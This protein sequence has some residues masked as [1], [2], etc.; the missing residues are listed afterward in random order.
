MPKNCRALQ[1]AGLLLCGVGFAIC[2]SGGVTGEPGSHFTVDSWSTREGLPQSSVISVIQTRDGYLWLGTLNGL[3]RFDGSH[4]KVF[5]EENTPGLKS[6]RIV[7]LFEDTRTNLWVGTDA[8]GVALVKDGRVTNF[9]IGRSGHDGG[10]LYA[11]EDLNGL[12][13][14]CTA[15]GRSGYYQNGKMQVVPGTISKELLLRASKTLL[16]SRSGGFWVMQNGRVQKWRDDRPEKDFGPFPW[17][18]VPVSSA[19]EDKDGNLIVGTLGAGIFWYDADGKCRQISKEQGLS[20]TFVLS[21]CMDRDGNLW[22]GTD[23]DGLD[24]LKRKIFN[25]PAEFHPWPAQSLAE[26][27]QG[28]LWMTFG[29]LGA[30]YWR[31]NSMQDFHVGRSQNAWTVLVDHEQQI[32]MGTR[33]EG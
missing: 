28:G 32:W 4:F 22:V 21:L 33:E 16:P 10:L 12:V 29:A 6:D 18:T 24:R 13:W 8:G 1:F 5:D 27:A 20:S 14:F 26:D 9:E 31:T 3:V 2:S 15:D 7:F 23:G 11:F 19:S 17:G 30:S 25:A